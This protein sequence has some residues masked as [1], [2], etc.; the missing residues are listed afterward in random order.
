MARCTRYWYLRVVR[1]HASDHNIARGLALGVFIGALPIIPFQS[2]VV[3]ALAFLLRTN[4]FSAWLATCYSNVFT[5]VP[6]Y[7]FLYRIGILV[8]PVPGLVFNPDQLTMRELIQT[9]WDLFGV[10]TLGGILFGVPAALITYVL[11]L[12]SVQRYRRIKR[13]RRAQRRSV[14][15][16]TSSR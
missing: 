1:Q 2:V 9:G 11:S 4:K 13:E 16:S 10:M 15:G 6:F 8:A 7:Y 12:K 14:A 3:I 5:L